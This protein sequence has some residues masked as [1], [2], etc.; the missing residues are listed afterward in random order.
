MNLTQQ[1]EGVQL[2]KLKQ[3]IQ[4]KINF[5]YKSVNCAVQTTI[6]YIHWDMTSLRI[7]AHACT[8]IIDAW[9][10]NF[11]THSFR[12]VGETLCYQIKRNVASG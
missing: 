8:V 5:Q 9:L 6:H 3:T 12:Y 1:F 4:N 7:T 10:V 2:A 11:P